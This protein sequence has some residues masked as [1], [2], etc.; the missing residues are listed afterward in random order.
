MT[1]LLSF[2]CLLTTRCYA[3]VNGFD[4]SIVMG[5]GDVKR[6]YLFSSKSKI[7]GIHIELI[8]HAMLTRKELRNFINEQK[9]DKRRVSVREDGQ[10]YMF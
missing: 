8:N 9:L 10:R 6:A 7:V 2:F 5:K 1:A 3:R 4:G